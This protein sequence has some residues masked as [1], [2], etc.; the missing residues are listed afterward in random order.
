MADNTLNSSAQGSWLER[1]F[2]LYSRGSTLRTECLA[3]ITGF[4]AAAY[5]LVVIP[6]LLAVGGMDKGAATTGTIL[7]FVGGTLLMAFY[8]NLPFIVGPGIGGSVL[9]GVTLAGSEGIGWQVG[10]GIACWSGILFFLLTK[11]GLREVVTRSVPQSIKLGLTASIG[12][13]VAVLG[14]RNAG[15]VLANAKT[16]ALMLGDFLSPGA[17]VALCGLF[18]AIALQARKIP[19]SIL[20]A[21]LFATLVGIPMGVTRLPGSFIDMPHS[22]TPVLGQIDMLGAL[23]IA[24]LPFPVCVLRFR[25]LFHHGHYPGSGRRSGSAG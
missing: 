3:G 7:V 11:F 14:F 6:G 9:V 19:G 15:L 2:A 8:A 13:F 23:N 18:L 1:R 17:L 22:L 10:L 4:L 21:I 20:W 24:F 12:L 5:L 16:N 25:V